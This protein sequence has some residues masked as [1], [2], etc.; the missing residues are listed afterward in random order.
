MTEEDLTPLSI[1]KILLSSKSKN[2]SPG[3]KIKYSKMFEQFITFL[4]LDVA[5]PMRKR[6]ETLEER[7]IRTGTLEDIQFV[8]D[9]HYS[10]LGK[11]RGPGLV[12]TKRRACKKL[13]SQEEMDTILSERSDV[14]KQSLTEDYSEFDIDRV[15]EI[16]NDLIA[17]AVIRLGRR[18]KEIITMTMEEV[19]G[20]ETITIDGGATNYVVKVY[21]QKDLRAGNEAPIA[22]T[23]EEYDAL[24]KYG[25]ILRPKLT[26]EDGCHTIFTTTNKKTNNSLS[27]SGVYNILQLYETSTGKKLSS[28]AIR[29]SL[30]TNSRYLDMSHQEQEDLA[31]SMSHTL[32]TAQ[33]YYNYKNI[34][35]SVSKALSKKRERSSSAHENFGESSQTPRTSTPCKKTKIDKEDPNESVISL[36]CRKVKKAKKK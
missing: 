27:F 18:T 2:L 1:K 22:F 14:L 26:I 32:P 25:N 29:G 15:T 33:R 31:S 34:T 20:A 8:F 35:D 13:M 12:T 24:K 5:S 3:T 10:Q 21:D 30:V 28:R 4:L 6:T 9:S 19:F 23:E 17:V 7:A 11:K 16:R 36:R